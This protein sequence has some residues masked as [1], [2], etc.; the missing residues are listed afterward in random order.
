MSSLD[1]LLQAERQDFDPVEDPPRLA[2]VL[3][4]SWKEGALGVFDGFRIGSASPQ[5]RETQKLISS[6]TQEPF[7]T[8]YYVA[9]LLQLSIKPDSQFE[10]KEEDAHTG[11][12]RKAEDDSELD[13]GR[14]V[15]ENLSI[16][17][18]TWVEGREWLN[19]RQ[20]VCLSQ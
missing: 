17:Y 6:V 1:P 5:R 8:P 13:C 12:K 16:A 4:R 3:R 11:E 20:C 14:D 15:L 7:K 19:V 18:R 2:K 9:L 10:V